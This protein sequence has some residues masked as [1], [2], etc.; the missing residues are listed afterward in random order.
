MKPRP[1]PR[2]WPIVLLLALAVSVEAALTV[3]SFGYTKRQK[4]VLLAE[5][6][7]S[8]KSTGEVAFK[9]KLTINEVHGNWLQVS[10]GP[11]AGWVYNGNISA[12][13]PEEIKGVDGLPIAASQTTATAAGR[14]L[15]EPTV[16][17]Y[18]AQHNLVNAKGDF[19]WLLK[20][21]SA[22][23]PEQIEDFLKNQKRGEYQ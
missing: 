23:T 16:E 9:R 14:P 13:E 3:G 8:A 17:A 11:V 12:T 7:P 10:D 1:A 19:D 5:P 4:T 15:D 18:A 20:Q 6:T 21:A 2:L 22:V